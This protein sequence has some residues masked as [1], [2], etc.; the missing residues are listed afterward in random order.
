MLIPPFSRLRATVLLGA[1]LCCRSGPAD[2]M[3][4]PTD[5]TR[6]TEFG[7][8]SF[9]MT[10]R[11]VLR[12]DAPTSHQPDPAT[13][14]PTDGH[15]TDRPAASHPDAADG[16]LPT[17]VNRL[18][19][20]PA[21]APSSSAT[22]WLVAG[23]CSLIIVVLGL[24]LEAIRPAPTDKQLRLRHDDPPNPTWL[25]LE[26]PLPP[27]EQGVPPETDSPTDAAADDEPSATL[28][29][30]VGLPARPPR[31]YRFDPQILTTADGQR[32]SVTCRMIVERS[33]GGVHTA[34]DPALLEWYLRWAVSTSQSHAAQTSQDHVSQQLMRLADAELRLKH[35]VIRTV[36]VTVTP[37][38]SS[39]ASTNQ[40]EEMTR[41]LC[42]N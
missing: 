3:T 17:R 13:S 12:T 36:Q 14:T 32:V 8:P 40:P 29:Q 26:C 34:V 7:L 4:V 15:H 21:R 1:F 11:P 37:V 2:I 5:S 19:A 41:E 23:V 16:R 42:V 6:S 18:A 20:P 31:V 28:P 33:S 39:P 22:P 35:I 27:A 30:H 9:P 25:D 38:A 24:F 10:H